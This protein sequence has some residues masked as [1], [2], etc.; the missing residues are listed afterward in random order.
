MSSKKQE[1]QLAL[2]EY[3]C[4][5]PV[6][7]SVHVVQLF[8]FLCCVVLCLCVLLVFASDSG[9]SIPLRFSLTFIVLTIFYGVVNSQN[10]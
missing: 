9:L 8:S 2:C 7:G 1:E 3:L 10:R 5:S 6:F 4:S